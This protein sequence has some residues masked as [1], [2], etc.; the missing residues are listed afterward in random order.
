MSRY[1]FL[2]LLSLVIVSCGDSASDGIKTKDP[3]WL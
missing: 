3:P 2:I 1:L